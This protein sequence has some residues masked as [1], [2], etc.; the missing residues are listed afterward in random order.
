MKVNQNKHLVELAAVM[1][2]LSTLNHEQLQAVKTIEGP[3]L[4]L[5]GAGSG[6]T[7]VVTFRIV[8]LI[9]AGI[10]PWS[11]LGVTFT[12]KAAAE[13]RERI[14]KLTEHQVL[15]CTFH[16]L[17]VRVL[18]ESIT[19][20]GYE[21]DFIIYDENDVE[22]LLKACLFELNIKDK[23]VDIKPY[24]QLIS[25]AKNS[26]LTPDQVDTTELTTDVE[27]NFPKVY[28]LYQAK[29]KQYN[30][31]DFDDLLFLTVRLWREHPEILARYQHRW[32]FVSIDE[33]QDT[34]AAQYTMT[35]LLVERSLNLFVVGDPDQSIYSWRGANIENIL[36]FERDYP[37]AKIVRLEQNYR[38]SMNILE[39]ANTLIGQNTNRYEKN[40]W[41]DLGPGEKIKLFLGSDERDEADFVASQVR[42]HVDKNHVPLKEMVVFYRTN[43]QSR[44]FEDSLLYKGIPYIIVGG[45]SFYQRREIK[46]ILAFLR[47]SHSGADFISF[48]RTINLPKRGL[49][50]ASIEKMRWAADEEGITILAYCEALIQEKPLKHVA[51]LSAKQREGLK[52][53]LEGIH[54]L[55][56]LNRKQASIREI[57]IAAIEQTRYLE[58]LME[59][60]ET[61]EDRKENLDELIAKAVEWEFLAETPTLESFLEELSLKSTLDEVSEEDDRLNLMTIHNGKGL[62][63]K[64]TFLVGLEEDL[65]PH[66]NSK[67]SLE[68]IEEERRLCYVGMT[69]AKE[70]L[71]LSYCQTRYLWGMLRSQ[72]QSRFLREIPGEY[73]E[74]IRHS[75][76]YGSRYIPA[77]EPIKSIAPAPVHVS[78]AVATIDLTEGDTVFHRDFGI[79]QIKEAYQGSMGLTYKIFF[80]KD[81]TLKTL[82]AKY[83]VLNKL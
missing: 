39:A 42:Q 30:A 65:F 49:G 31:V 76:S 43:A 17:G 55:K 29:L 66:V 48:L 32:Q 34:N 33:Y 41:S 45:L 15:I 13:M 24:R 72:R 7:R 23:K 71:Y 21:R 9:E 74:K 56:Q 19:A 52:E 61:F 40:L 8:H 67:D 22:K 78:S 12:N 20:L 44:A 69:R 1:V 37:G 64:V 75:G 26:L 35:R 53:Y 81:N 3:V 54:H 36:N 62:E 46:D 58:Y 16:S 38:S 68:Q 80:S 79:G 6:K 70:S 18:R 63:F 51:K 10:A 59:D 82:V 11:I 28:A 57:V 60:R 27:H 50:E 77:R 25:R 5:A 73:I 4:V 14:C 83:A 47:L 2:D